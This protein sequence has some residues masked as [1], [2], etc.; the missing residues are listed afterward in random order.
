M[1]AKADRRG[2]LA[3][4]ANENQ[5]TPEK[6]LPKRPHYHGHRERLRER[7]FSV[8]ADAL[9]DYELLELALFRRYSPA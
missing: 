6:S 3:A 9:S 4:D 7:F 2:I 8:G 1:V 5:Q